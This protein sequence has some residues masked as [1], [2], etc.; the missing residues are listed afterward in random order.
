[1][2][3]E[4]EPGIDGDSKG[5]PSMSHIAIF[6]FA[7]IGLLLFLVFLRIAIQGV[8]KAEPSSRAIS[9]VGQIVTLQGL[10]FKGTEQLLEPTEYRLLRST[11]ELSQVAKSF[12]KER[13]ALVLLW[14]SLLQQDVKSLWRFRRFLVRTGVPAT[15]SEEAEIFGTAILAIIVLN[16]LY[17]FVCVFGP[18]AFS[19]TTRSI[20]SLVERVSCASALILERL[21][22]SGWPELERNWLKSLG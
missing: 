2:V 18:F 3:R 11:P 12:R 14:I 21:P 16:F 9:A 22:Q 5:Y 13:K 20:R 10:S 6:V 17:V 19:D 15:L 4:L 8:P 7:T 1:M